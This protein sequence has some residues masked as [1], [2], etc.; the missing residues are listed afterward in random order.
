MRSSPSSFSSLSFL[1]S[2]TNRGQYF[3]CVTGIE[4][5]FYIKRKEK[6]SVSSLTHFN[7]FNTLGCIQN[8]IDTGI[9]IYVDGKI[10]V[11]VPSI[12]KYS[13]IKF[14]KSRT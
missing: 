13:C 9:S 6:Y 11:G 3:I 12:S 10:P 14:L 1:C 5:V 7:V 4:N 8:P 2:F